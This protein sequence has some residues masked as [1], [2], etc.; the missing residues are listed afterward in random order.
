MGHTSDS[1]IRVGLALILLIVVLVGGG[2]GSCAAYNGLRVWNAQV[3]GEAQLAQATQNRRIA[4]LEAQAALD[5]AKLK[6]AAEV[7]R[8]KGLAEAN[9]IVAD[10]LGGPEGYLR[11]LYIQNLEQSQG[12]I[13]YVPTEGGLPILEAGRLNPSN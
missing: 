11:Y 8:A 12:Q 13:I 6:A 4:V 2:L 5:S 9:R 3:A 7:E 10:S 1:L